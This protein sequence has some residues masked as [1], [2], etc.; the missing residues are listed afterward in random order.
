SRKPS[1]MR[2]AGGRPRRLATGA[3]RHGLVRELAEKLA[4]RCGVPP[5]ARVVIAVSGG[6]DSLALLLAAVGLRQRRN[7]GAG[8]VVDPVAVHVHHH[9][10][11]AGDDD[12]AFVTR[13]C[14]DFEVPLHTRHVYPDQCSGNVAAH[15][16]RLRYEALAEV[17][18]SVGA[19][20]VA[21]AHHAQD[22]LETMLMA[23]GRGGGI[24]ALSGMAWTRPLAD[25]IQLVRP[26][27]LT[28]KAS[29]EAMC[30]AAG[31]QWRR[32]PTN[33]DPATVRGRLRRDVITVLEE[34]WPSAPLGASLAAEDAAAARAALGHVIADVFGDPSVRRWDR[35][36]LGA[37]PVPVIAAGLR[38]AA[39]GA[40]PGP[41]V[42]IGRAQVLP[43]AEAVRDEIRRPRSWD[44]AEGLQVRVTAREVCL[45]RER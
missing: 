3:R 39:Q 9:L 37:L 16:R 36:R 43:V 28:P 25:G 35:S 44:W 11:A 30:T 29:C 27:L 5:G 18:A 21:V 45:V 20:Y 8:P 32:D 1:S 10:R 41:A 34:L 38:R 6:P 15:A 12:E 33:A 7:R 2:A 4:G 26:L 24:D 31:I 23:L 19:A 13:V 40:A 42:D 14:R 17:A 22:Q